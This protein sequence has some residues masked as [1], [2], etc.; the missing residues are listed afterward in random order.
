M[1]NSENFGAIESPFDEYEKAKVVVLQAPF[2]GTVSYGKGTS[3]GPRAIIEASKNMELY[4]EELEKN[5]FEVGIHTLPEL[6]IK[7]KKVEE[8][9][10]E[11]YQKAQQLLS[12][13]KFIVML[14]GEHSITPALVKAYKEKFP[15]ISVLQIDAHSDLRDEHDF[16]KFSH[17]CAMK[18]VL[19]LGVNIVQVGIRSTSEEEK[20]SFQKNRE[21][22]FMAKDL[23][24]WTWINEVISRL[25]ENVFITI[26]VDGLD[27]RIMPSTGTPE[28]GGLGWYK[29]IQ[30]LKRVA[31]E[32]KVVGFDVVELAP[33]QGLHAPDFL[34]AKLVYKLI[35]Y[36]FS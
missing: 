23:V 35:G 18:R 8:A 1:E 34:A 15:D 19:D 30:L 22:I 25:G 20:E 29:T 9:I 4:D 5:T 21:N 2:E 7:D 32:K 33:I 31:K 17:A 36:A 3:K 12:K 26:D 13:G 14:G 11:V 27:P 10:D 6:Q 28:P 24:G 16:T